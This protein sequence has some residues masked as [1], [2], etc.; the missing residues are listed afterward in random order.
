MVGIVIGIQTNVPIKL[1]NR[2]IVLIYSGF[3]ALIAGGVYMIL[4]FQ[5][6]LFQDVFGTEMSNKLTN[7]LKKFKS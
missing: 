6:K 3:V 2:L 5:I 7:R 4:A 1:E